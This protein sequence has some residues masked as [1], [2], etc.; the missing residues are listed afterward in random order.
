MYIRPSHCM[1]LFT[2]MNINGCWK[3]I[4]VKID[5]EITISFHTGPHCSYERKGDAQHM[6]QHVAT[7]SEFSI[8]TFI[9]F[10]IVEAMKLRSKSLGKIFWHLLIFQI[11]IC[12]FKSDNIW[13][14]S[15][16]IEKYFGGLNNTTSSNIN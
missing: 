7:W 1:Q 10:N 13:F 9:K 6:A 4:D 5:H 2:F 14:H 12:Y 15:R 8:H 16:D 3:K 11:L